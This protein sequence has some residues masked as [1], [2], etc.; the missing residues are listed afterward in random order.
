[1]QE[2]LFKYK[3]GIKENIVVNKAHRLKPSPESTRKKA[4]IIFCKLHS[5][6]DEVKVFQNAKIVTR[7]NNSINEDFSQETLGYRKKL[8][9]GVKQLQSEGKSA[10][11]NYCTVACQERKDSYN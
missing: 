6:M 11:L 8:W 10:Y 5:C 4:E 2:T 3:L 1:M 9:K 7:T